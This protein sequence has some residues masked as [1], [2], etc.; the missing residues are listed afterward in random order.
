MLQI[1]ISQSTLKP[2]VLPTLNWKANPADK[3]AGQEMTQDYSLSQL[4]DALP[5]R[6]KRTGVLGRSVEGY[7][8]LLNLTDPRPASVLILSDH[9]SGKTTLLK[10]LAASLARLNR[11]EDVRFAVIS[12]RPEEWEELEAHYPSHFMQ[13]TSNIA[14]LAV[15]L[16]YHLGDLVEDRQKSGRSGTA[17]VLL[18]DGMDTLPEMDFELRE[19][20]EWLVRFGAR[21]Q[22]W[23][24]ATLD[25]AAM[26]YQ[27]HYADLFRTR[28]T[29]AVTDPKVASRLLSPPLQKLAGDASDRHFAVRIQQNWLK[30]YLLIP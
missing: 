24:A 26:L 27:R 2:G 25:P 1:P 23:T 9:Q 12:A 17:Y 29:G 7:P 28:I 5:A 3:P 8:L 16:I 15:E 22:I 14:V 4:L 13:I 20:F 10:T 21:Q 30:F 11:A 19:N 6:L 18:F